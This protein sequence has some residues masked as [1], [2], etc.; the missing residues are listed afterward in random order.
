MPVGPGLPSSLVH[1][2]QFTPVRSPCAAL[3]S[4]VAPGQGQLL[5]QVC[6][7][8]LFFRLSHTHTHKHTLA[9]ARTRSYIYGKLL[10]LMIIAGCTASVVSVPARGIRLLLS[11]PVFGCLLLLLLCLFVVFFDSLHSL[12]SLFSVYLAVHWHCQCHCCHCSCRFLFACAVFFISLYSPIFCCCFYFYFYYFY[13]I[14]F[15]HV[16]V[17]VAV[18]GAYHFRC[19][20]NCFTDFLLLS[21][22]LS[23]CGAFFIIH[24]FFGIFMMFTLWRHDGASVV[25]GHWSKISC[26]QPRFAHGESNR[27][28]P[29][30][31]GRVKQVNMKQT[32]R[33]IN[34]HILHTLLGRKFL[35]LLVNL[36]EG[37][38]IYS[39]A[40]SRI[41]SSGGFQREFDFLLGE[42]FFS[43]NL[44]CEMV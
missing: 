42:C 31:W 25:V 19:C 23:T 35:K 24:R 5:L 8:S 28:R 10:L 20:L 44:N 22:S 39:L 1:T 30:I 6:I 32:E 12:F 26:L 33:M 15:S 4:L 14:A 17:V 27:I 37:I 16:A 34:K 3:S 36:F 9:H 13:L 11:L 43:W 2:L 7:F 40:Y 29:S 21:L 38:S 41:L 18:G